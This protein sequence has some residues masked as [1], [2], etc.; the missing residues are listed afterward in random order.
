MKTVLRLISKG[1]SNYIDID[2]PLNFTPSKG[3]NFVYKKESYIVSY[4]EYDFDDN[5]LYIISIK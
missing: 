2:N 3:D 5:T 4:I 1:G